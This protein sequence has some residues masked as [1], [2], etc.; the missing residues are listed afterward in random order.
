MTFTNELNSYVFTLQEEQRVGVS[1]VPEPV[2]EG[3]D[4]ENT[5]SDVRGRIPDDAEATAVMVGTLDELE[6]PAMAFVRLA[7]GCHLGNLT[8]LPLPVRFIFVLLGPPREDDQYREIGRSIATLMS[9]E[10]G[11]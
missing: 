6:K 4:I 7:K 10:V 5:T 8:E 11:G 3:I 9:D 2:V 1:F